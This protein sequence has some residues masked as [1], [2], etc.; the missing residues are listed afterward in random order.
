MQTM[1]N[2][3]WGAIVVNLRRIQKEK[4]FRKKIFA[5]VENFGQVNIFN[6]EDYLGFRVFVCLFG[7]PFAKF[8]IQRSRF[9]EWINEEASL[10]D[11]EVF[12]NF[13]R[14]EVVLV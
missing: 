8:G 7:C 4:K 2:H 1:S 9:F 6:F 14:G 5:D 12:N 3:L 13:N 10:Q 11:I